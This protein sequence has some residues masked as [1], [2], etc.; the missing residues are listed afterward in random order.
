MSSGSNNKVPAWLF[1]QWLTSPETMVQTHLGGNM[2]P[3]RASAWADP[4]VAD[5]VNSWGAYTG[6]YVEVVSEMGQYAQILYPPH[7]ELTR[8]LD[9]WAEAIQQSYFE[10]GNVEANLCAA[11]EDITDILGL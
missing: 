3:V 10:G 8:A 11:E 5:L 7:A 1:L 2:N 4:D 6:Q 9:R